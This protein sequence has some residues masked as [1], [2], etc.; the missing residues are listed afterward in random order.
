MLV[1]HQMMMRSNIESIPPMLV[2]A[3]FVDVTLGPTRSAFLQFVAGH[4]A[5]LSDPNRI[6]ES[7][8]SASRFPDF[9]H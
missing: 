2:E 4:K 5:A 6:T 9:T 8:N 3:G 1:G 7:S